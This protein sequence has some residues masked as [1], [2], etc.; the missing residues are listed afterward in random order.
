VRNWAISIP[1]MK[2]TGITFKDIID[3]TET[4][5]EKALAK[6][7]PLHNVVLTM[8]IQHLPNPYEA[9]K[10]RVGKI[11]TGDLNS[12]VGKSMLE[13]NPEGPLAA[14][15]TKLYPDPHAGYVATVRIFSGKVVSGQDVLLISQQKTE[16]VQQVSLYKGAQRVPVEEVDAGNIVGIVGLKEAGSGETVCDPE[17]PIVAFEAIKHI[18]EPVVTK[19]IEPK[20]PNQ[21]AKL[22]AFLRKTAKEDPTMKIKIDEETGEYLVSGLGELHIDAKIERPLKDQGIE[23]DVSQPI[24]IFRESVAAVTLNP[25][26]G[27]SPNKHNKFY[28]VVEPLSK[29]VYQKMVDGEIPSDFEFKKKDVDLQ[30]K[31][32]KLGFDRDETK[33]IKLIHNRNMLI[34][35]TYG[36]HAILE[37]MEMVKEAFVEA[38]N[39]GPLAREP[40]SGIKVKLVDAKLHEDAIHRGPAQVIPAIREAVRDAILSSKPY[41][42]EPRQII[43]VDIPTDQMSGALKEINNRR[44]QVIEMHEERG[45]TNIKAKLP[46]AE[47]FGF[48]SSLKSSTGGQGFF[49]LI[50]VIYEQMPK[51]IE[52]K[53]IKQIKERKGIKDVAA[54]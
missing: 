1:F 49:W 52:P 47:M 50:D 46:V 53:F 11:W 31:L 17:K 34:D 2:K 12:D 35:M 33:K 21:L 40:C 10:Y 9:Q 23:V 24:V 51:D 36:V 20:H 41:I 30:E 26:E 22:I 48:N 4:G 44:G 45:S 29:E 28:I 7:A 15:V 14:V 6:K 27:K 42:L 13:C 16:K 39:E 8:V 37:V 25:I 38:M 43:R 19:A 18:F 3:M 32:V 5:E 54:A